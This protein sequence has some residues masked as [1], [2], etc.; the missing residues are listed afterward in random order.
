MFLLLKRINNELNGWFE[1]NIKLNKMNNPNDESK[2]NS[3]WNR[4]V[5]SRLGASKFRSR[6]IC[7]GLLRCTKADSPLGPKQQRCRRLYQ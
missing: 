7:V 4:F 2:S 1:R 3:L 6:L 5:S